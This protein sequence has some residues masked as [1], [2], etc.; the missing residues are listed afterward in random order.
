[1]GTCTKEE[2]EV[3]FIKK[4]PFLNPKSIC[5]NDYEFL[6]MEMKFWK[7]KSFMV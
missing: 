7:E 3:P 2:I 4:I 1:M 6:E 5:L